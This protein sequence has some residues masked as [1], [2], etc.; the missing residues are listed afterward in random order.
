[1]SIDV[2]EVEGCLCDAPAVV[3]ASGSPRRKEILSGLG[4]DFEIILPCGT[5]EPEFARGCCYSSSQIEKRVKD[6]AKSKVKCVVDIL[7]RESVRGE[8]LIIGADTVVVSRGKVLGKPADAEE[9]KVM[10]RSLS[11]HWHRVFTGLSVAQL[12]KRRIVASCSVT[13]VHFRHL[14]DEEIERYVSTG[15]PLDKA[16]AYGIQELGSLFVSE[17]RGCYSNVVGLPIIVLDSL[18]KRLGWNILEMQK[19]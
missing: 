9:A 14:Q 3:L 17:I 16:G 7:E 4:L 5:V 11:G 19:C 6:S 15:H 18:M 8:S 1:M 13:A 2:D 12:R 10:L